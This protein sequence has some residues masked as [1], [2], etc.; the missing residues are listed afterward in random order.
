MNKYATSNFRRN[1]KARFAVADV[2]A[3]D[4]VI[5]DLDGLKSITNDAEAVVNYLNAVAPNGLGERRIFY[6]DT[7]GRFD[8]I[9]TKN[10]AFDG[11]APCSPAQSEE[12]LKRSAWIAKSH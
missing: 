3:E 10:G 6:R 7:Q 1:L 4:L 11:F 9:K 8:E 2:T 5:V 12:L